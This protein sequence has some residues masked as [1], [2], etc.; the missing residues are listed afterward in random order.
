MDIPYRDE[1]GRVVHTKKRTHLVAKEGSFWPSGEPTMPYG[2][3]RLAKLPRDK[4]VLLVEGE[5]DCWTAWYHGINGVLG[6]PGSGTWR[7]E[8]ASFVKDRRRLYAWQEPDKAG[9]KFVRRIAKDAPDLRVIQPPDD[10]E[11]LSDLHRRCL[12]A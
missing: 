10:I 2:L 11:D 4:F 12:N 3:D 5:S 6:L 7:S 9:A 1:S 8:W